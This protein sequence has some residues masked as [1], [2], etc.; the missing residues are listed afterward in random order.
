MKQCRKLLE[1]DM[2][3]P[4]KTLDSDKTYVKELVEKV[5]HNLRSTFNVPSC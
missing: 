1:E 5:D 3:L 2:G 4:E